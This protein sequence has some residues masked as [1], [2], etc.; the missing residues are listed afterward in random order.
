MALPQR[1]GLESLGHIV[2]VGKTMSSI[3]KVRTTD[4]I[5]FSCQ[6]ASLNSKYKAGLVFKMYC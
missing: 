6:P 1:S 4:L 3:G 5:G 2:M